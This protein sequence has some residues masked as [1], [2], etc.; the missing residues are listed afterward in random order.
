ML[1][2]ALA[3]GLSYALRLL[4][5]D[6]AAAAFAVGA[7]VLEG[8]GLG[9]AVALLLFFCS[10]MGVSR[11]GRAQKEAL[12]GSLAPQPRNALQVLANGGPAAFLCGLHL[13]QPSPSLL[14]GALASLCAANADTWAT[15]VGIAF[16]KKPFRITTLERSAPG[17]SGVVTAQGLIAAF[18]GSMLVA[19]T[20]PL[21]SLTAF[22]GSLTV[23]GFGGALL[24]SLLGDTLEAKPEGG[25]LRWITNDVVNLISTSAAAG[26]GALLV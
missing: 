18:V 2:A 26:V 24:D 21:L 4:T 25:G 1:Y 13:L 20:S 11:L 16:G 15:E 6:G 22:A 8:G 14:A 3:A 17:R 23:V 12:G 19:T 7:L 10:S 9:M 5:I